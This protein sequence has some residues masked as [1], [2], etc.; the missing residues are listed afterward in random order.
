MASSLPPLK[1]LHAFSAVAGSQ[2]YADAAKRLGVTTSAVSQQL[3]T[4]EEWIG[5]DLL[6]RTTK[7]P[8]L[9]SAGQRL[10]DG[11]SPPL[12]R[13][14]DTCSAIR[15]ERDRDMLIVSAPT[16]YASFRLI[17]ALGAFWTKH[18]GIEIDVR[19]ASTFDAPFET[20]ST[21]LA[22]RFLH[23]H[24]TAEPLGL[25]GWRAV[26]RPDYFETL[27]RPERI[28]DLRSAVLLHER[29]YNFWLRA[30]GDAEQPVPDDLT[31]RGLADASQVLA[32][33]LA[34]GAIALLP[35]ELTIRLI[36]DGTLVS[37]FR[38]GFEPNASYFA[39]PGG[40]EEKNS[41]NLLVQHLA[42]LG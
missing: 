34:G 19:L 10:Y 26:C 11:I 4:L 29:T 9:T 38:V 5:V 2:R 20:G 23:E 39:F 33:V 28:E 31:F 22:I 42:A 13:I 14:T 1:A 37:P 41:V 21:D 15:R 40:T 8:R 18:P 16:A 17:P 25:R 35:S 36:F 6:D 3:R 7:R 27:G 30:F 32:A 12:D 24:D